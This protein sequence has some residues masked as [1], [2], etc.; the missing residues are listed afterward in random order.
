MHVKEKKAPQEQ[1]S[2]SVM[3]VVHSSCQ[4]WC[5]QRLVIKPGDKIIST[6]SISAQIHLSSLLTL[7]QILFL[8]NNNYYIYYIKINFFM[9]ILNI[10]L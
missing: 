3:Q 7:R 6:L 1:I 8:N 5:Y 2:Q 9:F 4:C 10:F